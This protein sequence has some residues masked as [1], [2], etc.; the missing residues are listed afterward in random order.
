MT[1]SPL[2][3]FFLL[4]FLLHSAIALSA[5][6]AEPADRYGI[7]GRQAPEL[8]LVSWINGEGQHVPEVPL[9]ELRGKV[10]Y[11]YFFQDWCPGCQ[12]HGFP[13]L[14]ILYDTLKDDPDVVL[15]AVQTTFEGHFT[16]TA[17]KLRKNQLKYDLPISMAHDP[18]IEGQRL[19]ETMLKYRSGG[20]PWTVVINKEG[21]VVFNQ[22]NIAPD[23]AIDLIRR[24]KKE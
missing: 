3:S 8:S 11:L 10:I 21:Q 20:T 2:C 15:L 18:G 23:Q 22:F 4:F 12:S 19:P 24:L 9:S 13:T 14:K 1:R 6:S 7:L 5:E 17:E 16:N